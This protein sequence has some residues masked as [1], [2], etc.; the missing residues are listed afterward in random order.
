MEARLG[1]HML[2]IR[3]TDEPGFIGGLG[4]TLGDA[5]INIATF[6]LGRDHPGGDAIA[7]VEIDQSAPDTV[8]ATI[9]KL[10]SV[11]QVK[12]LRF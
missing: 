7:L 12:P 5:A 3:N 10:P 6:H 2:Y 8:I 1:P 4:R 11:L 9:R